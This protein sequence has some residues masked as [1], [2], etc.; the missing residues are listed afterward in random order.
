[1]GRYIAFPG[2]R[3]AMCRSLACLSALFSGTKGSPLAAIAAVGQL[4]ITAVLRAW[5]GGGALHETVSPLMLAVTLGVILCVIGSRK[6][7]G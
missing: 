5:P 1:M 6:F 4:R 2:S 7:G 3:S